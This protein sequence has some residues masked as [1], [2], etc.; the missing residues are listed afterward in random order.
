MLQF[1]L[2]RASSGKTYTVTQKIAE[3]I[4]GGV[5]PVLLVPEQFSFES[6]K[7]I[8]DRV[9]DG[10]A[11]RVS[12][13]SFTRLCDEIERINGGVCG[14]SLSGADKIILMNRA[15]SLCRDE[16]QRFKKYSKSSSFAALILDSITE[17]KQSF[18][19]A[20]DLY[21]AADD[22]DDEQLKL[23]LLDTALIYQNYD[24]IIAE[25]FIDDTDR[26][27]K[28]YYALNTYKYF[29][30][31]TVFIDSFKS[32][33]GQQYKILEQIIS[34]AAS[35]TITLTDNPQDTRQFGLFANIKKVK[36]NITVIAQKFAVPVAD[37]IVLSTKNYESDCLAL[38]EDFM[39]TG[40]SDVTVKNDSICLCRADS[41]YAEADFVARNIRRIVRQTGARYSDFVIIAR[42]TAPYE[43]ALSVACQKNNVSCFIDRRIPLLSTP[44]A[45]ALIAAANTA[46]KFSTENILRFHKSGIGVLTTDEIAQL[47]NYTYLW[48]VDGSRWTDE[49]TMD[50]DGFITR[51]KQSSSV[52]KQLSK[53]NALRE[54][55]IAPLKRLKD[56]FYGTA[57][58][59]ARALV[60]T[61]DDFNAADRFKT[62]AKEYG[63]DA[64]YNDAVKQSWQRLMHILN[65]LNSCFGEKEISKREFYDALAMSVLLETVG[66]IPQMVDEAIFGAADRIRPSRPKYAFIMGANQGVFPR[67]EQNFG[68][69]ANNERDVLIAKGLEIPDKTFAAAVDEDHLLYT[70]VCCASHGVFISYAATFDGV[71]AAEPSAFFVDIKNKFEGVVV[72]ETN[73]LDKN[74]L[75]ESYEDALSKLCGSL[76][77]DNTADTVTLAAAVQGSEISNRIDSVIGCRTHVKQQL[78]ADTAK[79]LFGMRLRMSPSR[80][81]TY[82]RCQ[83]MYFVRYGLKV[84][85]LQPAEFNSLQRGTIIHYVLQRAVEDYGKD[86]SKLNNSQITDL[87]DK[88]INEYLGQ[89]IGYNDIETPYFKYLLTTIKR[90]LIFV[91]GRLSLEFAQSDF[92][93]V[94]CELSIGYDGDIPEISL[95]IDDGSVEL[96]GKV[97]RLDRWN[98]YVRIIDYKSGARNFK[99]PDILFGQNMQMLIYLYAVAKSE[100]FGGEPAGILYMPASRDKSGEKSKRRMNGLLAADSELINAMDKE[101]KGEFV[102]RLNEKA[103]SSSFINPEDFNKVFSFIETKIKSTANSILNG[104]VAV[105]PID[106]LDSDACKYCEYK[107]ICRIGD[108]KHKEV[109][110]LTNQ[111]VLEEIERQVGVN[112]I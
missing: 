88:Y 19:T 8:L 50:P 31:K 46:L 1:I 112:G 16:L 106:G 45:V 92:E 6:E 41:V 43:D 29:E 101:N 103:P 58:N 36:H 56:N 23:K 68:L 71:S 72:N 2:G 32:F 17:F 60:C 20:D 55:A 81:D 90:T 84:Q 52:D 18:I 3:C 104:N 98:G 37:D 47:E 7:N 69:F 4:N 78:T 91:V 100:Q 107:N 85:S 35:V 61:F 22:I 95:P 111:D 39:A 34:Q 73:A 74:Q 27:T 110:I 86:L 105:E 79:Q 54:K 93:P 82:N 24:A 10:A 64:V 94:K 14:E 40:K 44:P 30:G 15:I 77:A 96:I 53:L 87:V 75:P 5:D 59:M 102:P 66:V 108:T 48:G 11:Q 67:Q 12:V 33:S 21:A 9:G 70:N 49:W 28:L 109:P 25:R 42:D 26:L 83:F 65:S 89:V 76:S 99:L 97:D 80:F 51:E 13:I 57:Q 62:F 63:G 38:L